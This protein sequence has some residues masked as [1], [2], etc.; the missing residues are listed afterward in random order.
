[1]TRKLRIHVGLPK[2]G[3][4][5]LQ[6]ALFESRDYLDRR[7]VHYPSDVIEYRHQRLVSGLIDGLD[8]ALV[9]AFLPEAGSDQD[10]VWSAEGFSHNLYRFKKENL[11]ALI[12]ATQ[13]YERQ[14][15]LVIRRRETFLW[16][17]YKQCLINPVIPSVPYYGQDVG[18]QDFVALPY[19]RKLADFDQMSRDLVSCFRAAVTV[20]DYDALSVS[21]ILTQLTGVAMPEDIAVRRVNASFP[22]AAI[23]AVRRANRML[24]GSERD[25]EIARICQNPASA[26]SV[27]EPERG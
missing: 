15:F 5:A 22:D 1:M 11:D 23:D 19:I 10:V 6:R 20:L 17:L 27:L 7:K 8:A 2:T 25:E 4:S 13:D 21:Q 26:G 14:V 18:F 24:A 9:D 3:T 12:A 16:S